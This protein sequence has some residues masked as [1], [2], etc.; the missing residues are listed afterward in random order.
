M[1]LKLTDEYRSQLNREFAELQRLVE[2][3]QKLRLDEH[4]PI[5][6][7]DWEPPAECSEH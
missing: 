2:R 7:P 5:L 6:R 4:E 3:L 1:K